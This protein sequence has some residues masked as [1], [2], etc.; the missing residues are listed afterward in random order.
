MFTLGV[1]VLTSLK[2]THKYLELNS[3]PW[4]C[5][6]LSC[7]INIKNMCCNTQYCK[8]ITKVGTCIYKL[9]TR[10]FQLL[11]CDWIWQTRL[12]HSDT[13]SLMTLKYCNSMLEGAISFKFL[14]NVPCFVKFSLIYNLFLYL[15]CK[16][17]TKQIAIYGNPSSEKKGVCVIMLRWGSNSCVTNH[18]TLHNYSCTFRS[19]Q[20][21]LNM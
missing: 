6:C 20:R 12:P 7:M 5:S 10:S 3:F 15:V 19:K 14:P 11:L 17:S 8:Y 18:Y 4:K 21:M 1:D 9:F 2:F 16:I 13:S